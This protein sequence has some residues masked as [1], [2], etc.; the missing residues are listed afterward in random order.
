VTVI[1]AMILA[2]PGGALM[3]YAAAKP[4]ASAPGDWPEIS[5]DE[6]GLKGVPEEP[7]ADAVILIKTRNG[8]I[9]EK[10]ADTVNVLDYH[11]RIKILNERGKRYGEV[12]IP[13][14]KYSRVSNLKARTVKPDGTIVP[15]AP[16]QIFEKVVLQ[17]GEFKLTEWVFNFPAV[18]PGAILEYRYDRHDNFLRYVDPWYFAGPEFTLLS[19]VTQAVPAGAGYAVLCDLCSTTKPVIT[20]WRE[21]KA[22][23]QLYSVEL[24]R[25]RGYR[26][27]LMMPPE[28]EVTPRLEMVLQSWKD[29]YWEPLGRQDSLFTDWGSVAKYAD[30]YY[31]QAIKEGLGPLKP[32]VEEWV[33]GVADPEERMKTVV[34]HVQQ[35]FRYIA[36]NSVIGR[37]GSIEGLIK[38][39]AADNEEKAVLLVAALKTIGVNAQAA[40]ASGKDEGSVNPKFFSPS[41][42]THVIVAVPQAGGGTRWI[43]PTVTYAPMGFM[44]WK[45][46]GA[47]VLLIEGGKG[48]LTTLPAKNEISTTRYKVVTRPRADG[49]ADLDVEAEFL[50]EDAID[51]RD[52]LAPA[53][54]EARTAYMQRWVADRRPGTALRSQAIENLQDVDKPLLLKL[55]LEA[56][57]LVTLADELVLVQGCALTCMGSNP[58]S[59]GE[60]QYPFYIDR[61]WNEDETVVIQ[62]PA[63]MQVSQTPP[64]VVAKAAIGTYTFSCLSQGEAAARCSRQS[65]ARRNRWPAGEQT[66][67]RGMYDKIVQADRS[68]VAF[69]KPEAASD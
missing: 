8:K 1:L 47:D 54:E 69:G 16:D 46:S 41:Q 43:D 18:E 22:K 25:I 13:A 27:E 9:V 51:M 23:G 55:S 40:L 39:K 67:V 37:V 45:D 15:V 10:G 34:R 31:Q 20:P 32:I 60:R 49:K 21:G 29:V 56:P 12:R 61:G 38:N 48:E 42:F 52:D 66:A 19:R 3:A 65:V 59:K 7:E 30:F 24:K 33:K 5:A 57:G 2:P 44:P 68:T 11:W 64:A 58:I 17:V 14:Q 53:S 28:R 36:W 62:A 50:G 6:R 26:D 63:G 35:D 4:A